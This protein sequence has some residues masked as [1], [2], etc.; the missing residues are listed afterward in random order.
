MLERTANGTYALPAGADEC[1]VVVVKRGA[2]LGAR[3]APAALSTVPATAPPARDGV[4]G[5]YLC[6]AGAARA[7]TTPLE[8]MLLTDAHAAPVRA[9]RR[10]RVTFAAVS[11]AAALALALWSVD[12]ARERT[13]RQLTDRAVALEAEAGPASALQDQVSAYAREARWTVQLTERR[14][15]PVAVLA[16]L[17]TLPAE[18]TVLNVRAAGEEWQIDGRTDDAGAVVAHLAAL[19]GFENVRFV[20]ASSRFQE[21]SRSYETFAVAFRVRPAS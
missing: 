3:R 12:R 14:A 4:Q 2:L 15:D 13:L 10:G 18:A 16:A 5:E 21:G 8:R 20:S 6:A 17:G 9:R 7:L 11:C 19:P 1:G